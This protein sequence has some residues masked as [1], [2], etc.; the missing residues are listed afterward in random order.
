MA[1]EI[2]QHKDPTTLVDGVALAW[3]EWLR[4]GMGSPRRRSV[5][6]G[7]GRVFGRFLAAAASLLQADPAAWQSLD[8]FWGDERCV[9]PDS[10]DSNF[11]LAQESFLQPLRVVPQ[12]VHRLR[13]E[14]TPA[15]AARAAEAILRI[16]TGTRPGATPELDLIFL[17]MGEDGHVASL[18]PEAPPEV[19]ESTAVYLPVIGPKPP[20]QRLTFS[21]P[22]LA[23]AREVWIIASGA[24]KEAAWRES[25]RPDGNTPMARV[26]R[27]RR[28]TRIFTDISAAP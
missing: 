21:Y 8:F 15:E 20:P 3:L 22:V 27:E 6:L 2:V 4:S 17:G 24:G 28:H 1:W 5:A 12:H 18:F 11:R 14:A 26:L 23:R 13:G 9:P 7:G 16:A 19:T 10:A 25:L